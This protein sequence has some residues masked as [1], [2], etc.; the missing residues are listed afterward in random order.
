MG[1]ERVIEYCVGGGGG[2]GKLARASVEE[3]V[4]GVAART[5][6]PGGGSVA[7]TVA[8]L[9]SALGA[10]VGQM[11]FGKRQWEALDATVRRLIPPLHQA[12]T[13]MVPAIDADT[14]AFNAYMVRAEGLLSY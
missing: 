3:F 2:V 6:A 13:A 10:M 7:A 11:T 9:G 12:A 5:P 4:K 8:A 1:R 14:A